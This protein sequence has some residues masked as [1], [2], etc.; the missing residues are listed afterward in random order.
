MPQVESRKLS[1][2]WVTIRQPTRVYYR[3]LFPVLFLSQHIHSA[4]RDILVS[5]VLG[6]FDAENFL[7]PSSSLSTTQAL[8]LPRAS[9]IPLYFSIF[10]IILLI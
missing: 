4:W 9:T 6:L 3:V 1:M 2:A 8:L 7:C 5:I 10:A